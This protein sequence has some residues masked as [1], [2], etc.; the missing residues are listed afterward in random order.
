METESPVKQTDKEP[1]TVTETPSMLEAAVK[2]A[3]LGYYV[4]PLIE[5]QGKK[6]NTPYYSHKKSPPTNDEETVRILWSETPKANIGIVGLNCLILDLDEKDGKTGIADFNELVEHCKQDVTGCPVVVT[7]SGGRHYY[8]KKPDEDIKAS[9]GIIGLDGQKTGID[10]RVGNSFVVAPPSTH[11]SGNRYR[12]ERP[13]V[14]VDELPALNAE[15]IDLLPKKEKPVAGMAHPSSLVNTDSSEKDVIER[16][17]RYV[18]NMPPSIEHESGH[19]KLLAACNVIFWD[20]NLSRN[21]G[22]P[23]LLEFNSLCKPVWEDKDLEHKYDEVFKN[24]PKSER[25]GKAKQY[26]REP[27]VIYH[28]L[29]DNMRAGNQEGGKASTEPSTEQKKQPTPDKMSTTFG[30]VQ[31]ERKIYYRDPTPP[32]RWI[33]DRDKSSLFNTIRLEPKKTI[34]IGGAPGVGKSALVMQLAFNAVELNP[35]VRLLVANIEAPMEDIYAREIARRSHSG[36]LHIT[37]DTIL[38]KS[39][40]EDGIPKEGYIEEI[41]RIQNG[42]TQLEF[43]N[44][45]KFVNLE[46]VTSLSNVMTVAADFKA[47]IIVLDYLQRFSLTESDSKAETQTRIREVLTQTRIH[48][49]NGGYCFLIPTALNRGDGYQNTSIASFRDTSEVEY[50]ADSVYILGNWAPSCKDDK[51]TLKLPKTSCEYRKLTCH[52]SKNFKP[53]HVRLEFYGDYQLFKVSDEQDE[54]DESNEGTTSKG[55]KEKKA[56]GVHGLTLG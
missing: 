20:F 1:S 56:K 10:I 6:Y 53:Q 30:V 12:W 24:P 14:S 45:I 50:S 48:A 5:Q 41:E 27:V 22:W 37:L 40:F 47:N 18:M 16:C 36:N 33:T 29:A 32:V 35:D 54:Q 44:R 23:I 4:I 38:D 39:Y 8:F 11:K 25:G 28:K 21:D 13:L 15:F 7:G 26:E 46:Y 2:Y 43:D 52:K 34:V 17:R 19:D 42:M 49:V 55:R 9:T 31:A 3:G 51:G